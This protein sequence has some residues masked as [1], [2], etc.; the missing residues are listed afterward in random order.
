MSDTQ[1]RENPISNE[2]PESENGGKSLINVPN[3]Q[4]KVVQ[5]VLD[6]EKVAI[7]IE[8]YKKRIDK[9]KRDKFTFLVP[10]W[11]SLVP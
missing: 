4:E 11:V 6:D 1:D 9:A 8:A 5:E 2:L 3:S 10:V 7:L